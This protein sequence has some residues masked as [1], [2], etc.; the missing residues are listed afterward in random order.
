MSVFEIE[1]VA[2]REVECDIA[3]IGITFKASGDNSHE[4]S[5]K[6]MDQCDS[7]IE[8]ICKAGMKAKDFSYDEDTVNE[9]RYNNERRVYAERSINARIPFDMKNLNFIE[10]ILQEG[11]YD[12]ELSVEGDLSNRAELRT[13]LSKQAL[14]NSKKEAEQL[15]EV[16]GIKVKGV[17]SIRQD[18]W[19][20]REDTDYLCGEEL[21]LCSPM[22]APP[23]AS[24]D[25]G[26]KKI[27][28]SVKLKIKWILE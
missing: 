9:S 26:S 23:R 13:E 12:Y 28:E 1:G 7:F 11:K 20:D 27:E 4:A 5:Q 19:G 3:D 10:S 6:V 24:D 16:L 22:C 18:R 15:A 21:T 2:K 8:R 14:L 17:D 25:I